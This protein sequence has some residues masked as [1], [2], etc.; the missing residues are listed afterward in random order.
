MSNLFNIDIV[1]PE[2]SFLSKDNVFEVVIP[3]VE[4]EIGI[5]KDHIPIISFLKPG[6][7]RVFSEQILLLDSVHHQQ[8]LDLKF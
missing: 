4:G 7:I 6:I 2:Q 1:N 3:A 5:L 8:L